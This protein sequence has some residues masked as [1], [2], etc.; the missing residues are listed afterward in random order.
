LK[1]VY[2]YTIH[3]RNFLFELSYELIETAARTTVDS[4]GALCA[5]LFPNN[6]YLWIS[7]LD[8]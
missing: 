5:R 1:Y 8:S 7:K 6:R 2:I 4:K 3:K